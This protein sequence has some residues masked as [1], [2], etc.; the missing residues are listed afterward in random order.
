MAGRLCLSLW[1]PWASLVVLGL[2]RFETRSWSTRHR[3]ELLIHASQPIARSGIP[4]NVEAIA[5][6]VWGER[7]LRAVPFGA[8]VGSV[9][10][11]EV[12]RVERVDQRSDAD[13]VT[14]EKRLRLSITED[15]REIALGDYRDNRF[16]W[17]LSN[18]QPREPIAC[19]G[20]QRLFNLDP[21]LVAAFEH[22][23]GAPL[24]DWAP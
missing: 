20:R 12:Y 5:V 22:R 10:L 14:F 4:P 16:A 17:K 23:L 19:R 8:I 7:W 9:N 3:G 21:E 6:E 13:L 18:P 15:A 24:P 11:D 2:K 1:Q